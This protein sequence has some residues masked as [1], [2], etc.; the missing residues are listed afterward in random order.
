MWDEF[1]ENS[2]DY[3]NNMFN[4]TDEMNQSG[5]IWSSSDI[6]GIGRGGSITESDFTSY[7]DDGE[8]TT[9]R[10]MFGMLESFDGFMEEL[11]PAEDADPGSDDLSS[12]LIQYEGSEFAHEEKSYLKELT[13]T[14]N[15]MS[16]DIMGTRA[17]TFS[18][19]K[20]M[21]NT[22][23][24]TNLVGSGTINRANKG[25]NRA[26]EESVFDTYSDFLEDKSGIVGNISKAREDWWQFNQD[27][28]TSTLTNI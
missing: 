17:K 8:I 28:V 20:K 3:I 7:N 12:T 11:K 16:R 6:Y 24:K 19:K 18:D 14:Y 22:S 1:L 21:R 2:T 26:H 13:E 25:M 23:G 5:D 27:Q 9:D 10:S 4:Q 15:T